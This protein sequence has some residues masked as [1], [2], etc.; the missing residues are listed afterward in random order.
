MCKIFKFFWYF[1]KLSIFKAFMSSFFIWQQFGNTPCCRKLMS[2]NA[3]KGSWVTFS[4]NSFNA[5]IINYHFYGLFWPVIFSFSETCSTICSSRFVQRRTDIWRRNTLSRG[6][7]CACWWRFCSSRQH[8]QKT[9]RQPQTL[10]VKSPWQAPNQRH[11]T[12]RLSTGKKRVMRRN[13]ACTTNSQ[14]PKNGQCWKM[15]V[16]M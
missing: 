16:Q 15:L 3:T 4:L 12:R 5:T 13:I 11:T 2:K 10:P 14:V 1:Y 7:S 9:Q 6:C 8:P